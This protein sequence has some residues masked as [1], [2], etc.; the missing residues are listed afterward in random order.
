MSHDF[1][2]LGDVLIA[3]GEGGLELGIFGLQCGVGL[4]RGFEV[5]A[6]KL[7][8]MLPVGRCRGGWPFSACVKVP[9]EAVGEQEPCWAALAAG[10]VALL[11]VHGA[12]TGQL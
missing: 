5:C 9:L 10:D 3:L 8:Q 11:G 4:S 1:G 6:L 2:K 12:G 7:E